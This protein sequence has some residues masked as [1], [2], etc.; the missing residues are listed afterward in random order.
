[1]GLPSNFS[2]LSEL[3]KKSK[4][5]FIIQ[6][7]DFKLKKKKKK[8]K[9]WREPGL[10]FIE[11]KLKGSLPCPFNQF[12]ICEAALLSEQPIAPF[13]SVHSSQCLS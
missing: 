6:L 4:Y 11:A 3:K 10:S 7:P 5:N 2:T 9:V 1:M 12:F 8:E 13:Y